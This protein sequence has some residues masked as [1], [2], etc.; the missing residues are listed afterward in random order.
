MANVESALTPPTTLAELRLPPTFVADH[1]IRTLSF[2]GAMSILEMA[3]HWRVTSDIVAEVIEPLKAAGSIETDSHRSNLEVMQRWRLS[4]TGQAY[5]ATARARTW[6]AG[7]LP[8]SLQEFDRRTRAWTPE[9]ARRSSIRD[10]LATF[11]LDDAVADQIGQAAATGSSMA[12]GGMAHDEQRALAG[13]LT[14]AITGEIS[15]PQA[16]FAAGAVIRMFDP[17]V[18]RP[19]ALPAAEPTNEDS[20][21][22]RSRESPSQWSQVARPLVALTG[23]VMPSDITPA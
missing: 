9:Q 11:L 3:K 15:V 14:A 19:A 5:V 1:C 8:V 2:Q 17:R 12:L 18:H 6:Y 7:P 16:I 10:A 13:A 21:L 22:L 20:D 23:G 4:A